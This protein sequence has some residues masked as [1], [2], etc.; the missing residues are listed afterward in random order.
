MDE[1]L[2]NLMQYQTAFQAAA[3]LI[4][5]VEDMLSILSNLI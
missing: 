4:S 5:V 2:T 3:R 1:E